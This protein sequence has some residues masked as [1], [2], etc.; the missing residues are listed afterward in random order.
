MYYAHSYVEEFG[1]GEQ[2]YRDHIIGVYAGVKK[3]LDGLEKY[4]DE[5]KLKVLSKILYIAAEYHDLGKL[6]DQAQS[7]LSGNLIDTPMINHVEAGLAH[8]L[9]IYQETSK[10]EYLI[11]AYIIRSHHIGM[12]DLPDVIGK[13]AYKGQMRCNYLIKD[14]FR[15][16]KSCEKYIGID[17]CEIVR[18]YV[19]KNIKMYIERHNEEIGDDIKSQYDYN[20][21]RVDIVRYVLSNFVTLKMLVGIL[22]DADGNDTAINY[23]QIVTYPKTELMPE[24]RLQSVKEFVDYISTVNA[25]IEEAQ[26]QKNQKDQKERNDRNDRK[27]RNDMRMSLFTDVYNSEKYDDFMTLDATVGS[28]K[29]FVSMVKALKTAHKFN[30]RSINVILPYISLAEQS[31]CVYREA[32]SVDGQD[33]KYA[34]N[35]IH[36]LI[37]TKDI[38][39]KKYCKNFHSTINITTA[40]NFFAILASNKVSL[41]RHLHKFFAS[42]IIIDEYHTI[43]D[44]HQYWPCMILLMRDMVSNMSCKFILSSGTPKEY[45]ENVDII[46]C[47][48]P[49]GKKII[50]NI[51][52]IVS[53][54]KY[55]LMKEMEKK[56]VTFIDRSSDKITFMQL[57]DDVLKTPGDIFVVFNTTKKAKAFAVKLKEAQKERKVFLRYTLLTPYDRCRQYKEMK[58]ML[59][60]GNQK[61]I[62]VGTEGSDVGLDLSFDHAYKEMSSYYS[63]IQVSGRVNRGCEKEH[64]CTVAIFALSNNPMSDYGDMEKYHGNPSLKNEL[65]VWKEESLYEDGFSVESSQNMLDGS[66]NKMSSGDKNA[67][68][69]LVNSFNMCNFDKVDNDFNLIKN[70]SITILVNRDIYL[71]IVNDKCLDY[72]SIG[73]HCVSILASNKQIDKWKSD[74]VLIELI[75]DEESGKGANINYWLGVY[76]DFFGLD[77]ESF[78]PNIPITI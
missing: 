68:Q 53:E 21:D 40:V 7:I 2:R 24:Q 13:V 78:S 56:R 16:N 41:L 26:C 77:K 36:H 9:K 29:T 8:C 42:V 11:A 4:I 58:D 57:Q 23:N 3:I 39:H 52:P 17:P 14:E 31:C 32:M 63:H 46:N 43:S 37:N 70:N 75:R 35:T 66:I 50:E 45:W 33:E 27:E 34:I 61:V 59:K 51:L 10:L 6:D 5:R 30:M 15:D 69:D 73:E 22:C 74:G 28:G 67:M 60:S 1:C 38:F 71:D 64:K 49:S 44:K 48:D 19:D 25:Q 62:L 76:D 18:S 55:E 12:V 20:I 47:I 54:E 72:S 65:E